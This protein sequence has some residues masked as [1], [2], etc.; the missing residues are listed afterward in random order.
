MRESLHKNISYKSVMNIIDSEYKDFNKPFALVH[1]IARRVV[2]NRYDTT[3]KERRKI[4]IAEELLELHR[5]RKN[6]F[7][8]GVTNFPINK[9]EVKKIFNN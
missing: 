8:K 1:Y 9:I 7:L 6:I 4:K 5:E 3:G 2:L